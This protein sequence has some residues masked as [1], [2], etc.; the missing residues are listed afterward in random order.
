MACGGAGGRL[1]GPPTVPLP[2]HGGGWARG[3]VASDLKGVVLGQDAQ[4]WRSRAP[5]NVQW[6]LEFR[7]GTH[8]TPACIPQGL[9]GWADPFSLHF[10]EDF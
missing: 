10:W 6:G 4:G 5:V 7:L 8:L 2:C 9:P 1:T 3:G